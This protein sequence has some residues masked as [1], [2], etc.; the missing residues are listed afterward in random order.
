MGGVGDELAS[1]AVPPSRCRSS[2]TLK[3]FQGTRREWLI[4]L[5]EVLSVQSQPNAG[6]FPSSSTQG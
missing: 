5:S 2:G 4:R 3:A 6:V 1:L